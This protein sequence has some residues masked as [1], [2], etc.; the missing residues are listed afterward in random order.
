MGEMVSG[1]SGNRCCKEALT[2][3]V[4]ARRVSPPSPVLCVASRPVGASLVMP[5]T[6]VC[7]CE[8]NMFDRT[9]RHLSAAA[10]ENKIANWGALRQHVPEPP[11]RHE[12][13]A[14]L[15]SQTTMDIT[16]SSM[17]FLLV[18]HH[19]SVSVWYISQDP[20]DSAR[21]AH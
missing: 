21:G 14:S 12:Q 9:R 6:Y 10:A 11:K 3:R 1:E 19:L 2:R 7:S 18:K 17:P 15:V 13:P 4:G 20:F 5:G 8:L 16:R